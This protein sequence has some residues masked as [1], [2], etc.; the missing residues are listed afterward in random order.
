MSSTLNLTTSVTFTD[1]NGNT[2][3]LTNGRSGK[4]LTLTDGEGNY[5]NVKVAASATE[6][7]WTASDNIAAFEAVVIIARDK[8]LMLELVTDDAA[9][10]GE[11]V[12]TMRLAVDWPF[13]LGGDDSYANYTVVFAGG[14]LDKIEAI[15]V[16]NLTTDEARCEM[17]LC[18]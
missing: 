7:L 6:V 5:K 1:S 16:K 10:I 13:T 18:A 12:Y 14:T 2:K 11:E 3:T 8:E 15:R 17:L 9:D 4:T